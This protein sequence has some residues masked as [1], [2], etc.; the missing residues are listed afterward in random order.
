TDT[1]S[2]YDATILGLFMAEKY[3]TL[4]IILLDFFLSN[5]IRNIH[6][7][8]KPGSKLLNANV[9]PNAEELKE[10]QRYRIT[11]NGISPRSIPGT[12]DGM[13]FSTGLEHDEH[14]RPNYSQKGHLSMTQKRY[15]KHQSVLEDAPGVIVDGMDEDMVDIGVV[16]WG[17]SAGA[18]KEAV[19]FAR[20]EGISA[21]VF[22]SMILSPF[23]DG[24]LK[25]FADRCKTILV[26]ELNYTGQFADYAAKVLQR[27]VEKLNYITGRPMASEDILQKMREL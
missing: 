24:D 25:S 9:A 11:E 23:P 4:V 8:E 18:A 27:P 3:Q 19:M 7:P 26:P 17:S 1:Q 10:Y 21:A 22:S 5:S 2:C 6:H 13:F 20:R 16:S 12:P 15:A 14:G